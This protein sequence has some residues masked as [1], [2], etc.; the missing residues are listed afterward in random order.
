M[1]T[2]PAASQEKAVRVAAYIRVS[3]TNP[4]Q[5]DSYEMQERYFMSLL[6]GNADGHLPAFIPIMAFPQQA[7]KDGQDSTVCSDTASRGRL[8]V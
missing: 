2:V 5:E 1:P 4:A 3:S 8:T 6:A 7:G